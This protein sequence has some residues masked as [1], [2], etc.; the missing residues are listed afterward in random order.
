ML[1]TKDVLS[2]NVWKYILTFIPLYLLA[3]Y[4][5]GYLLYIGGYIS[6]IKIFKVLLLL[7]I[8][9]LSYLFIHFFQKKKIKLDLKFQSLFI[10]PLFMPYNISFLYFTFLITIYNAS[11]RFKNLPLLILLLS[12]FFFYQNPA[13]DLNVYVL[14][15]WDKLWGRSIGGLGSSSTILAAFVF[16]ILKYTNIYKS[17]IAL[18]STCLFIILSI[19]FHRFDL[20]Y[21]GTALLSLIVLAPWNN[22]SPIQP[23]NQLIYSTIIPVIAFISSLFLNINI[24]I[25]VSISLISLIYMIISHKNPKYI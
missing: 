14:N 13:E 15:S 6:F 17:S 12:L 24:S 19:L 10:I 20:F 7:I 11:E 8:G 9:L 1:K 16:V 5:N 4:K 23:K 3:L 2:R 22:I 21:N 18:E 25:L